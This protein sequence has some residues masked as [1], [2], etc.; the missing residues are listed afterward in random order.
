MIATLI[1]INSSGNWPYGSKLGSL[2]TVRRKCGNAIGDRECQEAGVS[3][4]SVVAR[5]RYRGAK[6]KISKHAFA[7]PFEMLE[8]LMMI[9]PEKEPNFRIREGQAGKPKSTA[10]VTLSIM[11]G[12]M[13][14][15]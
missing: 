14:R 7:S 1:F 8:T 5:E 2:E 4:Y 12:D 9:N 10:Y 3:W 13:S 11:G 15:K 6:L